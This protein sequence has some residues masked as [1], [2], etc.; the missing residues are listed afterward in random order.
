ML[1]V[2]FTVVYFSGFNGL[3]DKEIH[4]IDLFSVPEGSIAQ[5][6]LKR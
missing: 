3:N 6:E 2:F 5:A 4:V 1:L